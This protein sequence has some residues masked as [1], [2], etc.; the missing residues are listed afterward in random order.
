MT[1][2]PIKQ[3]GEYTRLVKILTFET[4]IKKKHELTCTWVWASMNQSWSVPNAWPTRNS[5]L[6]ECTCGK[7]KEKFREVT[8]APL[9]TEANSKP[10]KALEPPITDQTEQSAHTTVSPL[11]E[12]QIRCEILPRRNHPAPIAAAALPNRRRARPRGSEPATSGR[13]ERA[14]GSR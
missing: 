5:G 4:S 12:S 1:A 2:R 8:A 13:R 7:D 11:T 6:T 10:L 9:L 14:L 3:A